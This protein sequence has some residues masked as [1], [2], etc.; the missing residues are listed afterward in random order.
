MYYTVY[1]DKRQPDLVL[2]TRIELVF[3]LYQSSVFPFNYKSIVSY[4]KYSEGNYM[5]FTQRLSSKVKEEIAVTVELRAERLAICN[6]CP[7]FNKSIRQCKQC[8]CFM[9][10]KTA[11]KPAKCPLEKW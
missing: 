1:S 11:L 7:E 6:V 10:A 8:G 9:D 4:Y 2:L 5:F 3:L